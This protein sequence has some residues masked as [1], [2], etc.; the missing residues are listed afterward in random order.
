MRRLKI[1]LLGLVMGGISVLAVVGEIGI[2]WYPPVAT[3]ADG[4][5]ASLNPGDVRLCMGARV[6]ASLGDRWSQDQWFACAQHF[7]KLHALEGIDVRYWSLLLSGAFTLASAFGFALALR[8]DRPPARVLRG[9]QLLTGATARRAFA[10][11]S[12]VES[13]MSGTGLE[14]LPGLLVSRERETRHWL[15]WGSVGAGKTQTMLHLI[16]AAIARGD[17]VLVLDV[18]GD[19][20]AG[21]PG[22]PLL[23]AP[24]DRRS[25]VWDVASDCRTKQDA[26]ELAARLIP[27]SDDPIWSDAAR[28]ILVACVAALQATKAERWSWH[29]LHEAATSDADTLL[30]FA[31]AYHRDA[32]RLLENPESRTTQS[33]LATFQAHMHV[34]AAL[35]DAWRDNGNGRFSVSRWLAHAWIGG[36]LALLASAVGSPS[37]KESRERRIWIFADEFPQ[38]PRL[39][40]FSTFLDLGRSKGVIAV[41][42][43]QDIAQLRATYGHE[44]AD[45]WV[46]MIGTKIVTQINAGRGAEEA[47]Q[48]IGDQEVERVERSET[49]V[50]ARASTTYA[51]RRDIRRVVTAAEIATRLGPRRDG[52]RV[53][54]LGQGADALELTVPYVS[55]PERRLGHV[56]ATWVSKASPSE[57]APQKSAQLR[58]VRPLPKAVAERIR[59]MGD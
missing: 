41:I 50:G 23:I 8:F 36:L 31:K 28:D 25:L 15:I 57:V 39:S 56:P 49:V 48:L 21:L 3:L 5:Q 30:H 17:G 46:G 20:T 2:A 4:C 9:R 44:R 24:Q 26:R 29:D 12:K 14:L 53:L 37:L 16:L 33:V 32:V 52:I 35:G 54:V 7:R 58:L 1:T 43:A 11:A 45:A 27:K 18:K 40:H 42:G 55:L 47:S 22:E 38:L 19:M 6:L 51:T 34:A 10:Q 59:E 13:R